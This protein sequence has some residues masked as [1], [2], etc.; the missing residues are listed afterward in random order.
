MQSAQI[1]NMKNKKLRKT[2]FTLV[3]LLVVISIMAI[4][5]VVISSSFRTVQMKSRDARRKSDLGS[6][7]KALNMY[8]NDVGAFPRVSDQYGID[9]NELMNNSGNKF[10]IDVGSKEV[11]YMIEMPRETTAGL[12]NYKYVVSSTGKSFKVFVNLE[13]TEDMSCLPKTDC[14]IGGINYL[15]ESDIGC[16]YG[17]SSSN[18]SINGDLL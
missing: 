7:S 11:V 1:K 12:K 14:V 5:T 18:I 4:L 10:A 3:E 6:I 16:C 2:G 17:I 9:V 13:N 8:Y 15:S